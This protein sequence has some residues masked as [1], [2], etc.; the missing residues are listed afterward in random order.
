MGLKESDLFE[1]EPTQEVLGSWHANLIYVNGKKCVLFVN[2]KTLFNFIRINLSRAER[3]FRI[4]RY[5]P[6]IWGDII[7]EKRSHL[8]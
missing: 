3:L 4:S 7:S 8:L 5:P 6:H 1:S 2:D